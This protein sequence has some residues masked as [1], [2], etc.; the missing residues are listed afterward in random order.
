M[1]RA[2]LITPFHYIK[3]RC[4]AVVAEAAAKRNKK[5]NR[6]LPYQCYNKSSICIDNVPLCRKHA[7]IQALDILLKKE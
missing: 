3:P 7:A 1:A 2:K 4:Q 5:M 6:I